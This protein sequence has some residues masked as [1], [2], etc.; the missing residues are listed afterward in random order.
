MSKFCNNC[1]KPLDDAMRFCDGC[2]APQEAAPQPVAPQQPQYQPPQAQQSVY[3]QPPQAV[4]PQ[5]PQ[6]PVPQRQAPAKNS[7][8]DFN[9]LLGEVKTVCKGLINRCKVDKKFMYTCIG[10]AGGALLAIIL[11]IVLL[12]G[13]GYTQ[14]IDTLINVTFK[15]KVSQI[16]NLAPAEY[17]EY[18]EEEYDI[19]IDDIID[20]AEDSFD[21]M[22]DYFE[23]EYGKNIRVTYK[24][25]D[26][27]KLSDKKIEGIAEALADKYDLDEDK[28]TDGYELEVEMTIKGSEDDDTDETEIT[29]I[30]YKGKWYAITWSKSGSNYRADFLTDF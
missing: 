21:D 16:K 19:E 3:Y 11:L 24:V 12:S 8:F 14:P 7:S 15:G 18:L 17:W 28:F 22:M 5:Q 9:K 25:V 4:A 29:V 10:I 23:D 2:G 20:E 26:K 1:G 30:K 13:G 6:Y 27:K